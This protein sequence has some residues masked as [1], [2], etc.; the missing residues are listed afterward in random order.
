MGL[1]Y[2]IKGTVQVWKAAF[3][4]FVLEIQSMVARFNGENKPFDV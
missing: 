4:T 1:N 2:I 3:C